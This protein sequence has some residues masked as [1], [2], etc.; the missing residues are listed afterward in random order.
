MTTTDSSTHVTDAEIER[1]W[2]KVLPGAA[3]VP[4]TDHLDVC[5]DCRR[6]VSRGHDL[7]AALTTLEPGQDREGQHVPESDVHAFVDGRLDPLSRHEI[8]THLGLCASCAAEVRDLQIWA[9]EER[10]RQAFEAAPAARRFR[11]TLW[12]GGLAAA[13]LLALAVIVPGLLRTGNPPTGD[14]VRDADSAVSLDPDRALAGPH[15]LSPDD[16]EGVRRILSTG[17]LSFPS[18]M[19]DLVGRRGVLLGDAPGVGFDVIA[20]VGTA[21]VDDRPSLRWTSAVPPATYVV[22]VQDQ[23]TGATISSPPLSGLEWR[24]ESP[25]ARGRIY[26]WQVAASVAGQDVVAPKPPDPPAKLFVLSATDAATV[27]QAPPSH[28]VRGI[29]FAQLGLLDEA[30]RAFSAMP[31]QSPEGNIAQRYLRQVRELRI[32]RPLSPEP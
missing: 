1:F 19:P 5:T 12:Y 21:V 27:A 23:T 9:A 20:P 28:L 29:L 17:Q 25:L 11:P 31:A 30:E 13:A 15:G 8:S 16:V 24:P 32:G 3:L 7:E 6:R 4:F 18:F 2:R 14:A 22:T 10:D 26:L